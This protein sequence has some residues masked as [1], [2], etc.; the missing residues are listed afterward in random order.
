MTFQPKV[1]P[2]E[3]GIDARSYEDGRVFFLKSSDNVLT[4]P[5]GITV[6]TLHLVVVVNAVK[7]HFVDVFGTLVEEVLC[8]VLLF[9]CV[10]EVGCLV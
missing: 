5:D 2:D 7:G 4:Q 1:W 3:V 8:A 9:P 10:M 6:K